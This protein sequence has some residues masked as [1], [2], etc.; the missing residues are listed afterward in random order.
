MCV[1]GA[2]G[3]TPPQIPPSASGAGQP[4]TPATSATTTAPAAP[5]APTGAVAGQ[6]GAGAA[7]LAGGPPGSL[8]AVVEQLVSALQAV[9][10][11]LGGGSVPTSGGGPATKAGGPTGEMR[12]FEAAARSTVAI[13]MPPDIAAGGASVIAY[14]DQVSAARTQR[15]AQL[16]QAIQ[17]DAAKFGTVNAIDQQQLVQEQ[18]LSEHIAGLA[19]KF[20]PIA[21]TIDPN[22]AA[23]I[24]DMVQE[25]NRN[26]Q[27][28]QTRVL[29]TVVQVEGGAKGL[30]ASFISS[31]L[32]LADAQSRFVV[33]MQGM[34]EQLAASSN[35]TGALDQAG[36]ARIT[37]RQGQ[38]AQF[39][40][41][42]KRVYDGAAANPAAAQAKV[43]AALAQP[44]LEGMIAALA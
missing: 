27:L 9:V 38:L 18:Q 23:G 21:A 31:G 19:E 28:S 36:L 34:Q 25:A 32:R 15:V 22:E 35:A 11:V 7:T 4:T 14:L 10:A 37:Q 13:Q 17:A 39:H 5:A 33:E 30:P 2:G 29:K 43:D 3:A 44:T 42:F 40:T 41:A 12:A 20:R 16:T 8:Q 6:A 26:G 1:S 24:V